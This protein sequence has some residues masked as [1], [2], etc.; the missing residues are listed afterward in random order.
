MNTTIIVITSLL[1]ITI[2]TLWFVIIAI[3]TTKKFTIQQLQNFN[4]IIHD[5]EKIKINFQDE[6]VAIQKL[7]DTFKS[8]IPVIRDLQK[9]QLTFNSIIANLNK[10]ADNLKRVTIDNKTL[11]SKNS[12]DI[13]SQIIKT[14]EQLKRFTK[15]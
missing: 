5:I 4:K 10:N 12:E 6:V 9:F 15:Q 11:L 8:V 14:S 7:G 13:K 1:I 3:K 2:A